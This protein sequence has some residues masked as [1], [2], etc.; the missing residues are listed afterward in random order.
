MFADELRTRVQKS[1]QSPGTAMY[2]GDEVD[3]LPTITVV[4]Y[5]DGNV[6][7]KIGH[8]LKECLFPEGTKGITW[9]NVEGLKDADLIKEVA[10]QYSLHPLT[11]EDILNVEQRPKVEEF[12]EYYFVVLRMLASPSDEDNFS[13]E[14]I[15]IVFGQ[16]FVLSFQEKGFH[17]FDI[18]RDR[19]AMSSGQR[20]RQNGSDYLAYRLIDV[21]VDK[22]FIVLEKLSEKI[23]STEEEIMANPS[24]ENAHQLYYLK[25]QILTARKAI[26]PMREAISHL[27]Q[28]DNE[29]I[30]S[31]TRVYLRDVYDH[32]VQAIDA[33][34][35]FRDVLSSMMDIYLTS[36]TN[37]MNEIMKVLTIIATIFIPITFIASVY[38]MNFDYMPELH[39]HWG[40]YTVLGV[41]FCVVSTMLI[42]FRCKKWL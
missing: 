35:G 23:E 33:M 29:L 14:Q 21:V 31:Y 12:D 4:N 26:W 25:H 5:H 13:V 17:L 27:L 39:Y 16:N 11:V 36:L 10:A 2:T 19:I 8:R 22:Y 7:K 3:G 6:Q 37:R 30:S 28:C 15:S 1:G 34:E 18:I 32:I 24:T 20:L 40:Y 41:M 42:F 9:I 38:G